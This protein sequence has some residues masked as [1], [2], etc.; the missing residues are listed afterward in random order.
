MI[1]NLADPFWGSLAAGL[2]LVIIVGTYHYIRT[3]V[4]LNVTNKQLSNI[5]SELNSLKTNH[6]EIISKINK[7]KKEEIEKTIKLALEFVS[8]RVDEIIKHNQP[9]AKYKSF[10]QMYLNQPMPKGNERTGR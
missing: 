4:T 9:P 5:L 6:E 2:L 3:L 7:D 1:I 10:L 8:K